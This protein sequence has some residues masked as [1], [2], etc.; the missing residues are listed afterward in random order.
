MS[1]QKYLRGRN[2]ASV[3]EGLEA[4]IREGALRP[5]E[6]LPTVRALA[7][8][9]S[10]SPTTV[11]AAYRALQRR[12]VLVAEGR[13]G[14]RVSFAPPV[15]VAAAPPLPA[16]ARDLASGNPDPSLLP[17]LAPALGR[18]V[19]RLGPPHLYD[20][21][22]NRP[23]LLELA[24]ERFAAD[25]LPTGALAVVSGALDGIER[26]LAARL[27]AG[28]RVAVEDPGF[29]GV[30]H[31]VRALGLTLLPVAVDDEGPLPGALAHALGRG[32]SAFVATP[33]A[34][35]PTGAALSAA[36]VRELRRVLRAHPDV[37]LVE[38]D[39]A[40]E[41]AGAPAR[42]LVARETRHFAI[43][44]SVSKG[45][46]PDL[47]LGVVSGDPETAARVE[48][49]Q[50]LGLRWVSHLLQRTVVELWRDRAIAAALRRAEETYAE[51]RRALLDALAAHGIEARGA[52]GL[53]VWVP[54]PAEAPVLQGL[55]SAGY[56]V[57][58]G[59]R[60]RL[61]SPPAVR[62]TTAALPAAQAP[63]VAAALAACLRPAARAS[64]V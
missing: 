43:V 34:Q 3:A 11:A 6:Q 15:P 9:L 46:G 62:V 61:Q 47:R 28:D 58:P 63:A 7:R 27:R 17:D 55:L 25:G 14:T 45:L 20:G 12:G 36:R 10:L 59:E 60:Y 2:A 40:V 26:V 39:H 57:A 42:T 31:L 5:A 24:R 23:E 52:T 53:N 30:L 44:R 22:A 33:R 37:L 50:M 8:E 41:V 13:R 38:D 64:P 29:G 48:G 16:R 56:A 35:N 49:R 18:V 51:R 1:L 4:A 32:A 19:A 21:A 54:V